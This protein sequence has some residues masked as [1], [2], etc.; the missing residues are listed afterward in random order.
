MD[1][2]LIIKVVHVVPAV[3][4]LLIGCVMLV[5]AKGTPGHKKLG[6]VWVSIM[7]FVAISGLTITGGR[8]EIYQGYG[9]IH[10]LSLL[11][12]VCLSLA[13]WGVRTKKY[14]LHATAMITPFVIS[15]VAALLAIFMQDRMLHQL[16]FSQ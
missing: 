16:F 6:W 7:G 1:N 5:R 3:V 9:F 15:I 14:R 13:I 11:T 12:L 8:F 4:A 10:I 2:S